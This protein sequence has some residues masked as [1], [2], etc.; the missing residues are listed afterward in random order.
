MRRFLVST[1][2]KNDASQFKKQR[3]QEEEEDDPGQNNI[4]QEQDL[5]KLSEEPFI[6]K[7]YLLDGQFFTVVKEDGSKLTAQCKNCS[8]I[9]QGQ[10]LS[11]GN[12]L[13]HIKVTT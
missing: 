8:K 11:T 9:I 2:D 3:L 5:S 4:I 10:K 6:N 13:S 1:V 7:S 12:F